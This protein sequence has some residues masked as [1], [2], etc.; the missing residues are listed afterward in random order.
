MIKKASLE[1]ELF[2]VLLLKGEVLKYSKEIQTMIANHY[3]VYEDG[4]YPELHITID[5]IKKQS[6]ESSTELIEEVLAHLSIE[7]IEIE[8]DKFV[9]YRGYEDNFLALKIKETPSLLELTNSLHN[10][11][12]DEGISVIENYDDWQFHIT[13]L[14]N[15]FASNP[16]T[17]H[18]F[19]SLCFFLEGKEKDYKSYSDRLEIWS[20]TMDPTKKCLASFQLGNHF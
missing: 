2:L 7:K 8:L 20:P 15:V 13:I 9:C 3:N 11:L 17:D 18:N 10:S 6:L 4:T 16:I 14:S 1:D 19:D 5:R 12:V